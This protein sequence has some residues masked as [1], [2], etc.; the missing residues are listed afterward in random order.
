[1][2]NMV[3]IHEIEKLEKE[4][5]ELPEEEAD[6]K[7]ALQKKIDNTIGSTNVGLSTCD[8]SGY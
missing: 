7:E 3:V 2:Q 5:G 8:K 4:L 1:M 6:K